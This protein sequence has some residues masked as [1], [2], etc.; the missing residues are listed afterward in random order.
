MSTF[1]S[2]T[3]FD[4]TVFAGI[5]FL[6]SAHI[7]APAPL[8]VGIA[9][10]SRV[11]NSIIKLAIDTHSK[12]WPIRGNNYAATNFIVN[13]ITIV[14]LAHFNIIATAGICILGTGA[15]LNAYRIYRAGY[16]EPSLGELMSW[17]NAR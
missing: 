17:G 6:Y 10:I 16:R 8:V 3:T 4:A 2:K 11:A 13:S 15:L 1:L 9:V 5:G 12:S 14:A 7:G